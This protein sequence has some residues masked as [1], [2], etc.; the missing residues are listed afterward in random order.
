MNIFYQLIQGLKKTLTS[1]CECTC[2]PCPEKTKLCPTS[3]ICINETLWCDGISDC[4]DD[5]LNCAKPSPGTIT[6]PTTE[7]SITEGWCSTL[8]IYSKKSY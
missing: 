3:N 8:T 1:T 2:K 7:P 5:E 6:I 4:G